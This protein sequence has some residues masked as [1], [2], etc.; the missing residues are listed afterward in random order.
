MSLVTGYD[1][2]SEEEED[3]DQESPAARQA[4]Q[5]PTRAAG[6]A[7]AAPAAPSSAA[8]GPAAAPGRLAA[9][10]RFPASARPTATPLP[11]LEELEDLGSSDEGED[12]P[13]SAAYAL[14]TQARA[15]APQATTTATSRRRADDDVNEDWRPA[16]AGAF[17]SVAPA[18]HRTA[19]AV[20]APLVFGA[21]AP[22]STAR[23]S[24]RA[25]RELVERGEDATS[26]LAAVGAAHISGAEIR[27]EASKL[28]E[29]D[30][31]V[32]GG[33]AGADAPKFGG[34]VWR[35]GEV[36]ATS[37]GRRSYQ[38]TSLAAQA[39]KRHREHGE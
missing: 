11:L 13:A 5:A 7:A 20:A 12:D 19:V 15:D 31:A 36:A 9:G 30:K 34:K 23:M 29:L 21:S 27:Q 25:V 8:A 39:L 24:E 28:M 18:P 37:T 33:R 22:A 10:T 2:A 14:G 32:G 4:T 17:S 26:A 38:I 1:D 3:L 6:R 16:D 35:G